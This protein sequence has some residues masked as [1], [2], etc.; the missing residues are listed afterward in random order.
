MGKK[1]KN[2]TN[3]L[4]K[5]QLSKKKKGKAN[6]PQKQQV[7]DV[8]PKEIV[9]SN[10]S[11]N[12][13][14]FIGINQNKARILSFTIFPVMAVVLAFWQNAVVF[15]ISIMGIAFN[16]WL[17]HNLYVLKD[18][19]LKEKELKEKELKEKELQNKEYVFN[20]GSEKDID[21]FYNFYKQ[22]GRLTIFC[23]NCDFIGIEKIKSVLLEKANT[24]DL[25]GAKS[26]T[27]WV[28]RDVLADSP[29]IREFI[30]LEYAAVKVIPDWCRE[31]NLIFSI[32]HGETNVCIIRDKTEKGSKGEIVVHPLYE[33][34]KILLLT[35][36]L[37]AVEKFGEA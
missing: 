15:V 19:E 3:L 22:E 17:T 18:K 13:I 34:A 7:M 31:E 12:L 14:I 5:Q 9:N 29:V 4:Q 32:R 10:E 23:H 30:S 8:G 36:F 21:F 27:L 24:V 16:I 6:L 1:R 2:K 20:K 28:N 35:L 37:K 11:K 33:Q 26:L 25:N